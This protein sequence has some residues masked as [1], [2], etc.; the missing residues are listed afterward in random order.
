MQNNRQPNN[1]RDFLA[2]ALQSGA[3]PFSLPGIKAKIFE[4]EKGLY[5]FARNEGLTVRLRPF[6]SVDH[7]NILV[8]RMAKNGKLLNAIVCD[9]NTKSR[10]VRGDNVRTIRMTSNFYLVNRGND[11]PPELWFLEP[12]WVK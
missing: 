4:D 7:Q 10:F 11:H 9:E 3:F 12:R 5:L 2:L 8:D 1:Q 6:V